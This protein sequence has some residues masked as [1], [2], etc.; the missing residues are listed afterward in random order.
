[1]SQEQEILIN[2]ILQAVNTYHNLDNGEIRNQ[3]EKY[4]LS[5]LKVINGEK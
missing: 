4:I 5:Q 2:S 1:M 3:L